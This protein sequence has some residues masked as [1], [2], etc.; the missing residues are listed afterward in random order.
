[1]SAWFWTFSFGTSCCCQVAFEK[2]N[3]SWSKATTP[4]CLQPQFGEL[5]SQSNNRRSHRSV[6]ELLLLPAIPVPLIHSLSIVLV[7]S[8]LCVYFYVSFSSSN[9]S[10]YCPP[11]LYPWYTESARPQAVSAVTYLFFLFICLTLESLYISQKFYV[12]GIQVLNVLGSGLYTNR[13]SKS[14]ENCGFFDIKGLPAQY[15]SGPGKL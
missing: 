13:D 10:C 8:D 11:S 9:S 6:P 5:R 12:S 3:L 14:F 4:C 15:S 2:S 1:M 7:C